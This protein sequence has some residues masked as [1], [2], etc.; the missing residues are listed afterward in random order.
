[1]SFKTIAQAPARLNRSELAVPGIRPEFFEKAALSDVDVVLLDL[2][3][4]VA[5]DDKE[6]ARVNVIEALH[7]IDWRSKSVS[8]RINGIDTPYMYR[9]LIEVVEQAGNKLD[10]IMVP[11]I[12][13]ASDV[14]AIDMLISQIEMAK[15]FEKRIGLELM[16]ETALGMQNINEIAAASSRSEALHFGAGDYAATLQ[17]RTT[18]IGGGNQNYAVLS[19]RREGDEVR[20]SYLGDM[21]HHA[22]S[23][24]VIAA[25]ANGLRP[26][27][28]AFGDFSDPDGYRASADRAAVMGFEGKWAI[29]PSQIELANQ[30]MS[31]MREEIEQAKR[32]LVALDEA[33][34]AGRGAVT[35]NGRM[36]DYASIRQAQMMVEKARMI[37]AR[38][39]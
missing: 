35:L 24:I 18:S 12:G 19:E 2:E 8:V 21:W 5:P 11:K 17:A 26:I 6:R 7:T 10:L 36:I 22:L 33:A 16:I 32:I 23:K 1:M 31:P 39:E 28:G 13:T 27:D 37:E 34:Q 20:Q 29:H 14:Y 25:R 4:S 9:D 15:G 3:D 38:K 30:S